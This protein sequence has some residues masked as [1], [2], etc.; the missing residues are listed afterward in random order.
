MVHFTFQTGF[1]NDKLIICN[2]NIIS[3]VIDL[4]HTNIFHASRM[5]SKNPNHMLKR[6]KVLIDFIESDTLYLSFFFLTKKTRK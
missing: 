3:E 4:D 1:Y 6:D 5:F 2:F